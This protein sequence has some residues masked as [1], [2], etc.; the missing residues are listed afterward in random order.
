[1]AIFRLPSDAD[2]AKLVVHGDIL[3][4]DFDEN[5]EDIGFATTINGMITGI[6]GRTPCPVILRRYEHL[7]L[8][9]HSC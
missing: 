8:G 5:C 4:G 9:W 3:A 7:G 6:F 2:A 1:M